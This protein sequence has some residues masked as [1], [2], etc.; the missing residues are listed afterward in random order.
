MT[1]TDARSQVPE[2]TVTPVTVTGQLN[3]L[4]LYATAVLLTKKLPTL[5]VTRSAQ[6]LGFWILIVV[7]GNKVDRSFANALEIV[8]THAAAGVS[9]A[10]SADTAPVYGVFVVMFVADWKVG[11]VV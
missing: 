11:G 6:Q 10:M 4:V 8:G 9:H 1:I 2:T 7:P 5:V 3:T